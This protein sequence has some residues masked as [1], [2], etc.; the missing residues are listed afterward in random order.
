M[1][2]NQK[3]AK[4]IKQR[5]LLK[6][7]LAKV[8]VYAILL[9]MYAP[10]L[11]LIVY[12]FTSSSQIGR[13]EGFSF[14]PFIRLFASNNRE[15]KQI[16]QA[17]YNTVSIAL[18]S[19]VISTVL[20]TTGA[21]GIFY[22]KKRS[23]NLLEF[24]TQIPVVN[25]EIVIALSLTILFVMVKAQFSYATLVIGHVVLTVPFVVLSVKP[26]LTQMDPN[27]YE[28]A[29]DLGANQTRALFK[30]VLPE[31]APGILSGFMLAVTL[32][33]DDYIITTFTKP[34][35]GFDTISTY[36]DAVTKKS[37]LPIQ[38]RALTT[39]IFA[40]ILIVMVAINIRSSSLAKRR[41]KKEHEKD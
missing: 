18:V 2:N 15:S 4:R 32:S 41:I 30:V 39:I 36:I 8:L 25:A 6:K 1:V 38:V 5:S 35:T 24:L 26:K 22:S 29:L 33:L 34:R 9:I 16:W 7:I 12:S 31:I 28:A 27:L 11:Y 23:K 3:A 13:W 19:G 40:V 17:V 21:I 20:G 14:E 10:I 37:G